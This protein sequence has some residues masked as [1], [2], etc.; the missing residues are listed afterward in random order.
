MAADAEDPKQQKPKRNVYAVGI[1]LL[2]SMTAILLGYDIGVMSGASIYIQRDMKINDVEVQI[3]GGI[4]S[5]CSLLG[6]SVA[7]R[8][9]DWVGRRYTIVLAGGIFFIGAILM[10]FAGNYVLLLIGRIVAGIG[11]GYAL[12]VSPVYS[13]EVAP[14]SVRGLLTSFT[15]VF[16]NLGILLGYVANFAFSGLPL[17]LGWRF[18]LGIGAIPSIGLALGVLGMPESP[19]WLVLQGRLGEAK[20]VLHKT[21]DTAT[22]AEL[23]LSDIKD[24]AGIPSDC[25]DNVVQVQQKGSH[26]EGVWKELLITPTP[27]VRRI[28]I[29]ALAVHFFQQASGIDA[30]VLY[31]PRIFEK[32]GITNDTEKLLATVAVGLVKF[33]CVIIA[34]FTMDRVGRKPLILSSMG[35]MVLSVA[36]LATALTII[37]RTGNTKLKWAIVLCILML[38][39]YVA[40]FSIGMGPMTYV[41]CT[42]IFP[43]KLRAQ[44]VSLGV[45]VNRLMSGLI[46]MTF[47]SLSKALTTGGAFYLFGA[48][49]AVGFFFF[50]FYLPE[51]KG[52]TLEEMEDLFSDSEWKQSR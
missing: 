10:G 9:S 1:A 27:A 21:S 46:S 14:A 6:S 47:L 50:F 43:L 30:V 39:V 49:A 11:V 16:V 31:S 34:T 4:L 51:T 38:L 8:T 24:A 5:V 25:N 40:F 41:Y 19:R 3:L 33:M 17:H 20:K 44:G 2:G 52:R 13:A 42:E 48:I 32:A 7:G 36:T 35:G 18:M 23:R 37:D 26:G 12:V 45:A 22:E 28:L 15:E 29:A